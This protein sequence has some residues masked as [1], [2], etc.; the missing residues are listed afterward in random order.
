MLANRAIESA[1]P[2]KVYDDAANPMT[3]TRN[4]SGF[5]RKI[6]RSLK[7]LSWHKSVSDL[8]GTMIAPKTDSTPTQSSKREKYVL[9][10]KLMESQ[11]L[12]LRLLYS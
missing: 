8:N 6:S 11:K 2:T 4:E 12:K 10:F 3:P 7:N 1:D 9:E 5:L